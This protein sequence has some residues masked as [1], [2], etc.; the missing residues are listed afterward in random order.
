MRYFIFLTVLFLLLACGD[1]ST[2]TDLGEEEQ[3]ECVECPIC[4]EK[5]EV[6][7][8]LE[9]WVYNPV[10]ERCVYDLCVNSN[11]EC[12]DGCEYGETDT[13]IGMKCKINF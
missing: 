8:C 1:T 7:E 12:K 6:P 2:G 3:T 4:E 5:P 9:H 10:F 13:E 11:N